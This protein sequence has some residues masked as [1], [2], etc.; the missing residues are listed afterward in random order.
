MGGPVYIRISS[1]RLRIRFVGSGKEFGDDP[2]FAVRE[3]PTIAALGHSAK[4]AKESDARLE[5]PRGF[6]SSENLIVDLSIASKP[7]AH[8]LF[9]VCP[10]LVEDSGAGSRRPSIGA[11]RSRPHRIRASKLAGNRVLNWRALW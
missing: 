10:P 2:V 1:T 7:V 3:D 9:S 6:G 8:G 4:L 5:L 11:G